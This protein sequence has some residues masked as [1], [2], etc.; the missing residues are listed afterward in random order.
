MN[1][2]SKADITILQIL[3]LKL[4]IGSVFNQKIF[5][6]YIFKIKK[7]T[8]VNIM[9]IIIRI[10]HKARI[11]LNSIEQSTF[12][13]VRSLLSIFVSSV[14]NIQIVTSITVYQ[15][16]LFFLLPLNNLCEIKTIIK[17]S[18]LIKNQNLTICVNI[19]SNIPFESPFSEV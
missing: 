8:S 12:R 5:Q 16:K 14:K 6:I 15:E 2:Y 13:K 3:F 7:K 19:T 1:I 10:N 17:L 18:I 11:I 9:S 4:Q